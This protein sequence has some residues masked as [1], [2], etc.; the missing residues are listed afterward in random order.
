MRSFVEQV[1]RFY[2]RG[3]YKKTQIDAMFAAGKITQ[4]EYEY[5]LGENDA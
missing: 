4:A 2:D 5:I 3:V 1:K